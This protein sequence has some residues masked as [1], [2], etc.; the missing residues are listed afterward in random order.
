MDSYRVYFYP[1]TS[2]DLGPVTTGSRCSVDVKASDSQAAVRLV[3]SQYNGRVQGA[4]A[5][6]IR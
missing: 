3:E 1:I 4:Y 5:E 2:G 6:R